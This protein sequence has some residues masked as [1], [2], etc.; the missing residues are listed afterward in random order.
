MIVHDSAVVN[1][2][3][4][5]VGVRFA[6][7]SSI[8]ATMSRR[9]VAVIDDDVGQRTF[10]ETQF[11]KLGGDVKSFSSG[12]DFLTRGCNSQWDLVVID[13]CMSGLNGVQT[14]ASLPVHMLENTK[15]HAQLKHAEGQLQSAVC[16]STVVVAIDMP[17]A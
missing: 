14:V 5:G 10:I 11:A 9:A 1:S 3:A 15:V 13:Y 7:P 6:V 2:A 17:T 4:A 12:Q 8:G 16:T